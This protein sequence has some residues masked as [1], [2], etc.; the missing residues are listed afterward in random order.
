MI[1]HGLAGAASRSKVLCLGHLERLSLPQGGVKKMFRMHRE[2]GSGGE[3]FSV[4]GASV[5]ETQDKKTL[6]LALSQGERGREECPGRQW[7]YQE[8][9]RIKSRSI[10]ML[11][12][13]SFAAKDCGDDSARGGR[14]EDLEKLYHKW[15]IWGGPHGD[16]KRPLV[17]SPGAPSLVA[18]GCWKPWKGRPSPWPL[19]RG[20]G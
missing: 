20:E 8:L 17:P 19:P 6:T 10:K 13:S 11:L 12:Q 5:S 18:G 16:P 2:R 7:V 1:M 4:A 9:V 15:P 3:R 14:N